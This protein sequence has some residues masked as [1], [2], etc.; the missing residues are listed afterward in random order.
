MACRLCLADEPL[1]KS[2]IIPEF[3][4]L[5]MYDEN[6]RFIEV[7]DARNQVVRSGQKGWWERLLCKDCEARLNRYEKHVR[8]MF[9]D[10]LQQTAPDKRIYSFPNVE[11]RKL[12]LF[13][14]SVLWRA[15]VASIP[16]CV[17]VS[18]GP[19]EEDL[20]QLILAD[21]DIEPGRFGCIAF[22]LFD[23]DRHL[24]DFMAEPTYHREG[25]SRCYRF[26]MRGFVFFIFVGR[27]EPEGPFGR[28]LLGKKPVTEVI[29]MDWS[30]FGF[31]RQVFAAVA[32]IP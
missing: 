28:L 8:R 18:L 10:P 2:H 20:R 4:F 25:R 17:H 27:E 19:Y 26:V 7:A 31:L 1:C 24:V 30:D 23:D 9:T 15:G 32:A 5:P 12:K 14:L 16:E 3:C 21:A 6:H 22:L 13:L 11:Y 29:R